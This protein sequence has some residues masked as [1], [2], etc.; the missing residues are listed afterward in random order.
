MFSSK[1]NL[2]AGLVFKVQGFMSS[3]PPSTSC[4]YFPKSS[5]CYLGDIDRWT[6]RGYDL[7][8]PTS[9]ASRH[10]DGQ[11][12]M[13]SG[14]QRRGV[15]C[16]HAHMHVIVDVCVCV[17]VCMAYL[18][19]ALPDT[20][21]CTASSSCQT[22]CSWPAAPASSSPWRYTPPAYQN[23]HE[24]CQ[25][26]DW[27]RISLRPSSCVCVCVCVCFPLTTPAAQATGWGRPWRFSCSPA[28]P[29]TSCGRPWRWSGRCRPPGSECRPPCR[30]WVRLWRG[31]TQTEP[32]RRSVEKRRGCH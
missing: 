20:C 8:L 15:K 6:R 4:P 23:T 12:C 30:G 1:Q 22:R 14:T 17:C 13:L 29:A 19:C 31:R 10:T 32:W 3:K 2:H 7:L 18:H 9:S 21:L 28:C 16:T 5:P 24:Q 11:T 25:L 27:R 26:K